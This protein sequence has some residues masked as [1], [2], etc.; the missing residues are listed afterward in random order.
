MAPPLATA[1]VGEGCG[2]GTKDVE[3]LDRVEV[4]QG[5]KAGW[6]V[7]RIPA[8][9]DLAPWVV[10]NTSIVNGLSVV[11]REGGRRVVDV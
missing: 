7:R 1:L 11:R 2:C 4:L 6:S 3:D 9:I 8:H 5:I 10:K